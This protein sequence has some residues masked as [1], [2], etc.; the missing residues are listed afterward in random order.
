MTTHSGTSGMGSHK[1]GTSGHVHTNTHFTG[2]SRSITAPVKRKRK[3]TR[4]QRRL[5]R[6]THRNKYASPATT[7]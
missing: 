5:K 2:K 4:K 3:A 1:H 6:G 7:G